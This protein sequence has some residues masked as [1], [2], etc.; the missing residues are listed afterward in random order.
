MKRKIKVGEV[1]FTV[2]FLLVLFLVFSILISLV[3]GK[4][5]NIFGY[6]VLFVETDSME[7]D[8]PAKSMILVKSRDFEKE[9]PKVNEVVCYKTDKVIPGQIVL[10]TH[11][12]IE[13]GDGYVVTKGDNAIGNDGKIDI[14]QIEFSYVGNMPVV[15]AI[16]K[17]VKEPWGF[18][19][20]VIIPCVGVIG[21]LVFNLYKNFQKMEE[22]KKQAE[23]QARIEEIKKQAIEDYLKNN[24]NSPLVCDNNHE[25]NQVDNN[26][27]ITQ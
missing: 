12:V 17:V 18:A 23:E 5:P 7:P 25:E 9:P 20:L 10:M 3:Q 1:I 11:R 2:L 24:N 16:A 27:E 26:E 6:S 19:I 13:V 21:A 22:E 14:S 15:S 8:I 4:T